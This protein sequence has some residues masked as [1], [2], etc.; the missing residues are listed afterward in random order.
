[1]RAVGSRPASTAAQLHPVRLTNGT[2]LRDTVR[3]M[4]LRAA[5]CLLVLGTGVIAHAREVVVGGKNFTEQLLMAELTMQLLR[6]ANIPAVRRTGLG[7]AA[8]RRAQEEG[9]IDLYWE[10]TGT[11]L[12]TFNRVTDR[13]SPAETLE[14]V[15]QLDA[16]RGLV[17][18]TPSRVTNTYALA[19]RG[20]DVARNGIRTLSDL[21]ARSRAGQDFGLACN[22]E[23]W[24]RP[25]GLA[26]VQREYAFTFSPDSVLRIDTS[27]VYRALRDG[28]ADVGLVFATDGR[29][30][31]YDFVVLADDRHVFPDYTMVPVIRRQALEEAPAIAEVLARLAAKLDNAVMARLNASVDME[32]RLIE[33]VAAT[34]LRSE[35]LL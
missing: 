33:E 1:M 5:L 19:M 6:A 8:I 35:G 16:A 21:A 4:L 27:L 12:V 14:R 30:Q 11:S 25:D 2:S 34:F 22:S 10:Y 18:L 23:F 7:T 24:S 29:V 13:L 9:R 26:A 3:Y 28:Q 20:S 17:W 15:K 32:K 31:A